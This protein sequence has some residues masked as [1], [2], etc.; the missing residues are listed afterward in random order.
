M[1]PDCIAVELS[2]ARQIKSMLRNAVDNAEELL[3][4]HDEARGRTTKKNLM[5][6]E[7]YES[8]IAN[9]RNMIALL[10]SM[11]NTPPTED[12]NNAKN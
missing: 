8:E 9:A 3:A 11:D 1:S 10:N 6:A 2:T 12:K 7:M 5:T 4:Y